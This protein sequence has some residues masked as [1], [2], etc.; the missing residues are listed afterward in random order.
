MTNA[1]QA[2]LRRKWIHL[3]QRHLDLMVQRQSRERTRLSGLTFRSDS[4]DDL[5]PPERVGLRQPR[6]ARTVEDDQAAAAEEERDWVFESEEECDAAIARM[7]GIP[8]D[9]RYL[10]F[11]FM[12]KTFH[13]D[14]PNNTL[15]AGEAARLLERRHGFFYLRSRRWWFLSYEEWRDVVRDFNPV[16]KEYLNSDTRSAAE[17]A[18]WIWFDLWR[19]PVERP[20]YYRAMHWGRVNRDWEGQGL[21]WDPSRDRP[22]S[23]RRNL[24]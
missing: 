16:Q 19:F 23:R 14:L 15:A 7:T 1:S 3:F 17:D 21:V 10:Q 11:G 8:D 18:A 6:G 5:L 2:G 24:P 9:N 12:K 22:A 20:L 4:P 13:M